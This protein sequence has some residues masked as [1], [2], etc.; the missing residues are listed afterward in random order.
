MAEYGVRE[1]AKSIVEARRWRNAVP[2]LR[3]YHSA[4]LAALRQA[5]RADDT[6]LRRSGLDGLLGA[7]VDRLVQCSS[8]FDDFLEAPAPVVALHQRHGRDVDAAVAGLR[9]ALLALLVDLITEGYAVPA[10]RTV[11]DEDLRQA[12]FDP[13]TPAPDPLDYW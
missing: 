8:P 6:G 4:K 11:T 7:A 10:G 12:G 1:L 13:R 5:L 3:D 2:D 9:G